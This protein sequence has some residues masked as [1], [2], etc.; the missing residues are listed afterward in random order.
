MG[1]TLAAVGTMLAFDFE[2]MGSNQGLKGSA[3]FSSKMREVFKK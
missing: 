1:L 2:A 3:W